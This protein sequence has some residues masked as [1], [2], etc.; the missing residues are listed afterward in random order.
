MMQTTTRLF[1]SVVFLASLASAQEYFPLAVGNQWIYR[2]GKETVVTGIEGTEKIA[3]REYFSYQ[4]ITGERRSLRYNDRGQLVVLQQ[5][6]SEGLWADFNAERYDTKIEQCTGPATIVARDYAID[7]GKQTL[8]G[9]LAVRYSPSICADAGITRDVF[10]HGIGLA[11]REITT[12]AGPRLYRLTYARV[13]GLA[14][15]GQ[16]EHAFRFSLDKLIYP[17]NAEFEA[18]MTLE[19]TTNQPV[20]LRFSSGQSFDLRIKNNRGENVYTWSATRLFPAVMREE[21]VVGEK[22]W[23]TSDRLA[24]EPGQYTM[25]A[26][27]TTLDRPVYSATVPLTILP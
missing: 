7:L 15:F 19:N 26:V 13:G 16:G 12:I 22:N 27:L 18:R 6:G 21:A 10:I 2:A 9:G 11:E 20:L 5:D 14:V 4:G 8:G 3:G 1:S 25:E 17:R 24:L 23:T